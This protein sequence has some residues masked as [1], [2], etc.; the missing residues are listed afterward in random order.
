MHFKTLVVFA[1]TLHKYLHLR[2]ATNLYR[3]IY[4]HL[5]LE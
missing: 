3:F 1:F 5:L 4:D 2:K